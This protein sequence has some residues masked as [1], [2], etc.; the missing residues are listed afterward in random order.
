MPSVRLV[1]SVTTITQVFVPTV[2][3]LV[4][5]TDCYRVVSYWIIQAFRRQGNSC[6]T[7]TKT[8][9][10]FCIPFFYRDRPLPGR[11]SFAFH[12][13]GFMWTGQHVFNP[14][15]KEL[16]LGHLSLT[17]HPFVT[18]IS[19]NSGTVHPVQHQGAPSS[20][21]SHVGTVVRDELVRDINSQHEM[22]VVIDD[23]W[24][25]YIA[26]RMRSP[27]RVDMGFV[28]GRG[29]GSAPGLLYSEH[30]VVHCAHHGNDVV[31]HPAC[32]DVVIFRLHK[33]NSVEAIVRH[34]GDRFWWSA[35]ARSGCTHDSYTFVT[36]PFQDSRIR[37][38]VVCTD[39]VLLGAGCTLSWQSFDQLQELVGH[40]ATCL[41]GV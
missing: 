10:C 36:T 31:I 17:A 9:N 19:V 37:K 12:N 34:V 41:L 18:D 21:T 6:H 24:D 4:P 3:A 1:R 14:H 28:G 38:V 25:P 5:F 23:D 16:L 7:V 8:F 26:M 32:N 15:D 29:S 20:A 2:H 13:I 39:N 11:R 40:T 35:F 27:H 30:G 22:I 33:I